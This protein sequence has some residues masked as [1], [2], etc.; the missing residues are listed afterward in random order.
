MFANNNLYDG[1]NAWAKQIFV[2]EKG[3]LKEDQIVLGNQNSPLPKKPAIIIHDPPVQSTRYGRTES[4]KADANGKVLFYNRYEKVITF[5]QV[6]GRGNF[7]EYLLNTSER[8]DIMD[9]FQNYCF[10]L[11]RAENLPN[12]T[13]ITEEHITR[14]VQ[15]DLVFQTVIQ[16]EYVPG[17]IETVGVDGTYNKE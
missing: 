15:M 5:E 17:Y 2:T 3:W 11:L 4:T 10:S 1:L 6:G 12:N 16:D 9:L 13:D 7:L 8:Q 14:R